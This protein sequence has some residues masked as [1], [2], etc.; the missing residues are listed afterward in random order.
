MPN[1]WK[2]QEPLNHS[3]FQGS[4]PLAVASESSPTVVLP[5][6]PWE[7]K[8]AESSGIAE[9]VPVVIVA[10]GDDRLATE[11]DELLRVRIRA[12][13]LALAATYSAGLIGK[14]IFF[15]PAM[16][17]IIPALMVSFLIPLILA[18]SSPRFF[19]TEQ[20]RKVELAV[21]GLSVAYIAFQ[22][23]R[24]LTYW[25]HRGGSLWVLNTVDIALIA[26]V[27]QMLVYGMLIPNTWRR[28]ALVVPAT[29]LV[30]L[31]TL[32]LRL[33]TDIEVF[34]VVRPAVTIEWFGASSLAAIAAA[35]LTVY[36]VGIVNTLRAE[37]NRSRKL[38]R[39]LLGGR[40]GSGGMGEVY[41]AEH[42]LMKRPCAIKLIRREI[43]GDHATLNRFEREVRA[44]ASLTHPNTIEIYDYGWTTDGRLYYVMEYLRGLDLQALVELY[45]PLPPE[46]VIHLLR[47]AC[48][49]LGEA[50][51]AGIIHRD[52][53]PANL[54][55]AQLGGLTDVVKVLD[56]GLAMIINDTSSIESKTERKVRGTPA[57]MAPEQ[58]LGGDP[59]DARADLYALGCVAYFL[60]TGHPPFD[61]GG[62]VDVMISHVRSPVSPPSQLRPDI[63]VDLEQV[64]MTCLAKSSCDRYRDAAQLSQALAACASAESWDLTRSTSWWTLR[65]PS[66][67]R[68]PQS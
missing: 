23:D 37:V 61:E 64:V 4:A 55:A 52:L 40:L 26:S 39:Y 1:L 46:R 6:G 17:W 15:W 44:T 34:R 32:S 13:C 21:F 68:A 10:E 9:R 36:G 28:A 49:A 5:P 41:L 14:L 16:V 43:A 2:S 54:F 33:A 42:V 12:A 25:A 24:S 11:P 63:P 18:L 22:Q 59:V 47:Q 20:L 45:G 65:E 51:A 8:R 57:Y 35:G 50:H 48:G 29:V 67:L 60:L 53:K 56:F 66:P 27:V 3:P 31:V 19:S 38:G 58:I 62:R 30:P 7:G